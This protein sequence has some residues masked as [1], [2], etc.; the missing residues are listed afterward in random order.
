MAYFI[1]D[2][3]WTAVGTQRLDDSQLILAAGFVQRR[4]A[5]LQIVSTSLKLVRAWVQLAAE[6]G[7]SGRHGHSSVRVTRALNHK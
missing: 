2:V 7:G 1:D 6:S 5:C 4:L 3:N